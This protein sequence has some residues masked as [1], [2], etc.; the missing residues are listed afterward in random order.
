M[1]HTHPFPYML[2]LCVYLSKVKIQFPCWAGFSHVTL[3]NMVS[4]W[5]TFVH[6][7][8]HEFKKSL[9]SN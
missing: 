2:S 7:K 9:S 3:G 5:D 4:N 1:T 8:T 6:I